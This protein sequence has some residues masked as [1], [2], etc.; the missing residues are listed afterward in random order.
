MVVDWYFL[1]PTGD[2]ASHFR[3]PVQFVTFTSDLQQL[4]CCCRFSAA[5]SQLFILFFNIFLLG[6]LLTALVAHAEIS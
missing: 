3:K 1:D 6:T 5:A 4:S 2:S